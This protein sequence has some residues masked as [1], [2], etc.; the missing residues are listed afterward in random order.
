MIKLKNTAL[1]QR[2]FI[3]A[4][5]AL[6][7]SCTTSDEIGQTSISDKKTSNKQTAPSTY[8][9]IFVQG[10]KNVIP[11]HFLKNYLD[12]NFSS[13]YY[14]NEL[15]NTN[16]GGSY[17]VD[18]KDQGGTG[19]DSYPSIT[20]GSTKIGGGYIVADKN[21][22][23]M[24]VRI[25]EISPTLNF[26]FQTSQQYANETTDKWMASINF[27]FDNYGP[28]TADVMDADRDYDLVVMHQSKNFNE[29]LDDNPLTA[30][31]SGAYWYFARNADGTIKP[32]NL[33]IGTTTYTYAVRY[34]FFNYPVGDANEDKNDKIHVKFI[35]YGNLPSVLKVNVKE[36]IQASKDFV[37]Y[38]KLPTA[39]IN[40]AKANIAVPNAL[41]KSISAGYEVYTGESLLSIDKFKINL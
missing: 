14:Y 3:T 13:M 38:A 30:Q 7:C 22:V 33:R 25:S 29:S 2:I 10:A 37:V 17:V 28:E 24:P 35:P 26:D 1:L 18:Y 31:T 34:K 11:Y 23:G 32:Y 20:I 27:I 12:T 41:L 19:M 15:F 9:K 5:F 40:L 8:T 6:V 16:N 4:T 21:V 36:I 39:Q